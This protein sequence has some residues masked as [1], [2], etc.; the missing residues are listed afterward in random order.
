MGAFLVEN[1]KSH[2]CAC[3]HS[4]VVHGVFDQRIFQHAHDMQRDGCDGAHRARASTMLADDGRA[5]EHTCADTLARHFE[6]AEMRDAADLN[7]GAIILQRILDAAF[8]RAIVAAFFHVDE[9][10]NDQTRQIAQAQLACDFVGCFQIGAQR[11][12][13][14]IM[15]ASRAA[16]VHV[17]CNQSFGLVDDDIAT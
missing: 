9:V 4:D 17:N 10:D 16:R 14:N 5:F 8:D 13:F 6:Q 2:F 1:I 12:V 7:A 3:A 15:F 11:C